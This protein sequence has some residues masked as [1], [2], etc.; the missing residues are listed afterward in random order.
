MARGVGIDRAAN[1]DR[2]QARAIAALARRAPVTPSGFILIDSDLRIAWQSPDGHW[3][4]ITIDNT[5]TI[6]TTDLGTGT[7]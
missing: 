1:T 6:T 4:E 3:W 2:R 5:G 7:P